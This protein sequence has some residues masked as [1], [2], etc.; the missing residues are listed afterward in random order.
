MYVRRAH[1]APLW[2]PSEPTDQASAQQTG[3]SR[4]PDTAPGLPITTAPD[5][6]S[7]VVLT[8]GPGVEST[9]QDRWAAPLPRLP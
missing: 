2:H 8:A 4:V 1:T 7:T 6:D 3:A 5:L 9:G